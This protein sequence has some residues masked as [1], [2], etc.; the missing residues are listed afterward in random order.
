MQDFKLQSTSFSGSSKSLI[1]EFTFF[2]QQLWKTC[3][4]IGIRA[5][6]PF[7]LVKPNTAWYGF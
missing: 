2:I 3:A 5:K 7:T 4:D 1:L 6:I